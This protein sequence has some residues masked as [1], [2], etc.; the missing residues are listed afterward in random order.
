[1]LAINNKELTMLEKAAHDYSRKVLFPDRE[2]NDAYPFGP[3][4]QTALDTAF[5]LDFFHTLVPESLGGLG[6][7]MTAFCVLIE[8][9][10]TEDSSLGAILLTHSAA[11]ELLLATGNLKELEAIVSQKTVGDM[12]MA[13]P[14][15]NNPSDMDRLPQAEPSNDG[16]HLKGGLDYL[17]LGGLGG[18]ALVPARTTDTRAYSWFLVDLKQSGIRKSGPVLSLGL[19]S[20]PAVDLV[21]DGAKALLIGEE[22]K[23]NAYFTTMADRMHTAAAAMSLGVMKGSLK[24]ALDYAK[25]RDQGGR[26]IIDWSEMKMILGNMAIQITVSDLIVSRSSTAVDEKEKN[27]QAGSR[28]AALHVQSLACDLTTDGV[29]AMGGVGYMKD[30]GQEKRFRDAKQLQS[31]LGMAPI[32]KI[33]FLEHL[34]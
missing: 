24:E 26:K 34:L 28:A 1:M 25:K 17:V 30:F 13:L 8:T 5:E 18:Q 2:T 14:V 32:K 6:H 22:N 11:V 23:G 16:F 10:C 7:G 3:F 12:L 15:F 29:Q 33:R 21:F 31:L 20:C 27:W 19:R 9:V 4:F